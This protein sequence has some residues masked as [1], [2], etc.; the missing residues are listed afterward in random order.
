MA[1]RLSYEWQNGPIPSG[2]VIDHLCSNPPC[3][4]PDH[5]RAVTQRVNVLAGQTIVAAQAGAAECSK[6]HPYSGDN[7]RID[8]NGHRVCVTCLREN[9]RKKDERRRHKIARGTA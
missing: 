2:L 1:H 7:L 5:L 9:W 3:V 4:R 8:K 6:G